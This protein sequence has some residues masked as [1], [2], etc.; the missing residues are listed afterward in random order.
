M[1][2]VIPPCT[3]MQVNTIWQTFVQ[4]FAMHIKIVALLQNVDKV[5]ILGVEVT[6]YGV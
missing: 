4:S 6:T 3:S 2:E 1:N 5:S